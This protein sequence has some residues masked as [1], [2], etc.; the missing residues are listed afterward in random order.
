MYSYPSIDIHS[1]QWL[2][3]CYM[4]NESDCSDNYV[5]HGVDACHRRVPKPSCPCPSLSREGTQTGL[6]LTAEIVSG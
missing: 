1:Y 2:G 4:P 5:F 6:V 3:G